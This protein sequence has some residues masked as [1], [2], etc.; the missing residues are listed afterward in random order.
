MRPVPFLPLLALVAGCHD[1]SEGGS[2]PLLTNHRLAAVALEGHGELWVATVQEI[3]QGGLDRNGDGD[4]LDFVL[5]VLD[6]A[7]GSLTELPLATTL[8]PTVGDTLVAFGVSEASQGDTDLNGDG[9]TLDVV[10]HVYDASTRATTSTGL[11]LG[12]LAP[13]IGLGVVAFGV[14]ESDQGGMDL[15]G[16]GTADGD[17]LYVH[18]SRTGVATSALRS[19]TSSP[20]F[21]DHAFAFTTDEAS[22]GGDL[23]GDGDADDVTIFET[24]D[25]VVGGVV[26]V[27]LAVAGM[28]LGALVENWY[29]LADE[30]AQG[31]D[32][33]GDLDL[34]D[35]VVLAVEPHLAT[36]QP[37]GLTSTTLPVG[38]SDGQRL[39]LLA[40]EEDGVDRNG[41][42]SLLDVFA[43]L[44][45]PDAAPTF[46]ADLPLISPLAL[47]TNGVAFL[48]SEDVVGD[49][50]ANGVL[51]E[52][53]LH[54]LEATSGTV[55][56]LDVEALTIDAA[57]AHVLFA[58]FESN[59]TIQEDRN[60]DGDVN[61][62]V[63][64][65]LDT[66]TGTLGDTGL[67]AG[68][69]LVPGTSAVLIPCDEAA[70]GQDQNADGDLGDLVWVRHELA[71][72][73]QTALA[74]SD[75]AFRSAGLA[76]DGRGVLLVRE[77]DTG[78]FP[79][80]DLNGDGDMGDLVLHSFPAP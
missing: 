73:L 30:A 17:V 70:Q 35:H 42:G 57:G 80:T 12:F 33:N 62:L 9:D 49:A 27:P 71:T 68:L 15:D 6:L 13:A 40:T 78:P 39:A 65:F 23:N 50:N 74:A 46:V 51:G 28:P 32:L 76:D 1:S 3:G 54:L 2:V 79:G 4:T 77:S 45:Q 11:A 5:A 63:H 48:V 52:H 66:A 21:H 41:N 60:A 14:S 44:I 43:A 64:A 29:V 25:L 67:A 36:L 18:D 58:R 20:V 56:A 16:D 75:P 26:S 7:D 69:M 37:T 24:Y 38:L 55:L 22:A 61:D 34:V 72:G 10:L 31:Q 8:L 47:T 59:G 53:I 19:V